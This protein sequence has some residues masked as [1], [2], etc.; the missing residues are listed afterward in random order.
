MQEESQPC[1][2]RGERGEGRACGGGGGGGGRGGTGGDTVGEAG[3]GGRRE[4]MDGLTACGK[5]SKRCQGKNNRV[6]LK[7][8]HST[9]H[10]RRVQKEYDMAIKRKV[11]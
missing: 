11:V 5:R 9:Y 1:R 3:A 4:E 2:H 6:E 10:L 7:I 8:A